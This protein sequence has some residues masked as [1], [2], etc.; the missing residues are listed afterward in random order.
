MENVVYTIIASTFID[1][2][3]E[4][5]IKQEK[6]PNEFEKVVI[7]V[8]FTASWLYN[9]NSRSV[10][11]P[12]YYTRTIQCFTDS[13]RQSSQSYDVSRSYVQDD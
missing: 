10:K 1:M 6:F 5:D 7:N 13:S 12:W 3:L 9:M 11:A 8:L 4:Q 2:S